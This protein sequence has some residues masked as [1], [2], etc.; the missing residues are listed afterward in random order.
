MKIIKKCTLNK[1]D[2][3]KY[4]KITKMK[5]EWTNESEITLLHSVMNNTKHIPIFLD[6]DLRQKSERTFPSTGSR[7]VF[8]CIVESAAYFLVNRHLT[9]F[10]WP[11]KTYL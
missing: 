6:Q 8:L 10:V 9:G 3:R 2:E 4:K 7:S 1:N 11:N 5:D